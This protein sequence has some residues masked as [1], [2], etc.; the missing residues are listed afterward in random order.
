MYKYAYMYCSEH[1]QWPP[2]PIRKYICHFFLNWTHPNIESI[3]SIEH[4]K[5]PSPR[6][7]VLPSLGKGHPASKEAGVPSKWTS[8][9]WERDGFH[10]VLVASPVN[11]GYSWGWLNMVKNHRTN[12]QVQIPKHGEKMSGWNSK[13][14]H[15]YR[16]CWIL[17]SWSIMKYCF[18]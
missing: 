10:R 9:A 11:K 5:P 13:H 6:G 12:N 15:V 2:F 1:T 7:V 3:E 4:V 16:N 17:V 18:T 8:R 14:T